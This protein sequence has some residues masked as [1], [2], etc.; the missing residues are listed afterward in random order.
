MILPS[1]VL[2]DLLNPELDEQSNVVV[3]DRDGKL[4]YETSLSKVADDKALL[5]A[6]ILSTVV[7]NKAVTKAAQTE[8]GSAAYVDLDG[9][10]VIAGFDNV[11]EL[12]WVILVEEHKGTLLAPVTDQ[13]RQASTSSSPERYSQ[14]SPRSCSPGVRRPSCARLPMK[15]EWSGL[16]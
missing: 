4:V 16:R 13:R 14:Q 3:V 2:T 8:T 5:S 1:G 11:D 7:T 15:R 12:G 6:G 10:D 9:H